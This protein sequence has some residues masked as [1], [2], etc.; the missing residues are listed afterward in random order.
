MLRRSR[1][2]LLTAV[3]CLGVVTPVVVSS[4]PGLSAP[5]PGGSD[6]LRHE[7]SMAAARTSVPV[8]VLLGVSYLESRWDLHKGLPSSSGAYGPMGLTD[9]EPPEST[10]L[11]RP[12]DERGEGNHLS[13]PSGSGGGASFGSDSLP[14]SVSTRYLWWNA[15]S[16]HH[17][18]TTTLN[19]L[20]LDA[21]R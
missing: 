21:V 9:V 2:R 16:S 18:D 7:F 10:V 15:E 4:E 20:D 19:V 14:V 1:W 13:A 17:G 11:A 3:M 5:P 8:D 6:N 12:G